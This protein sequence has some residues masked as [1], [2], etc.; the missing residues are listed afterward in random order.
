MAAT[1]GRLLVREFMHGP[2]DG[3]VM[4]VP[5]DVPGFYLPELDVISFGD[6]LGWERFC[7]VYVPDGGG[8]F[9]HADAPIERLSDVPSV[10][11]KHVF[12]GCE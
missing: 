8:R 6:A 5:A 11:T 10:G 12:G 2:C 7:H 1:V 9:Y 3:L 4:S